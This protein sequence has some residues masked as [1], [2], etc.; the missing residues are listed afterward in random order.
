M[1]LSVLSPS[2]RYA[3]ACHY[4]YDLHSSRGMHYA[5]R[6]G[7]RTDRRSLAVDFISPQLRFLPSFTTIITLCPLDPH[8]SSLS[9]QPV[10]LPF[11]LVPRIR[12][13]N[14]GENDGWKIPPLPPPPPDQVFCS[15]ARKSLL[16]RFAG[17]Y[18]RLAIFNER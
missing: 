5:L 4:I 17:E 7:I 18:V 13:I 9:P 3:I 11:S 1:F 15:A 10:P 12:T 16:F 8:R 2:T 14:D 6:N